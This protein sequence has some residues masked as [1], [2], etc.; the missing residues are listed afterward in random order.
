MTLTVPAAVMAAKPD[1][2]VTAI[3]VATVMP[4]K[5]ALNRTNTNGTAPSARGITRLP[6]IRISGNEF[7]GE[8]AESVCRFLM[9]EMRN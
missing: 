7:I 5:M 6:S 8:R 9:S 4:L 2:V 3:K 1:V